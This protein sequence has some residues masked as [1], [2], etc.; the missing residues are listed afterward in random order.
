MT[1]YLCQN[2][3]EELT[4]TSHQGFYYVVPCKC[5]CVALEEEIEALQDEVASRENDITNLEDEITKLEDELEET[6]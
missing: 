5:V 4:V 2:C 6:R 3:Q 1:S